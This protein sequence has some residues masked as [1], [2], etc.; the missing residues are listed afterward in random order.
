MSTEQ[1]P[2]LPARPLS[3]AQQRAR[4]AR[5]KAVQIT[6]G[7]TLA[8]VLGWGGWRLYGYGRA[9]LWE[10]RAREATAR[11]DYA[12]AA[13]WASRLTAARPRTDPTGWR[14]LA[15]A[16]DAAAS[17]DALLLRLKVAQLEPG[18]PENLFAWAKTALRLG[19]TDQA[20]DALALV[21]APARD[22][23]PYH[24]L[25]AAVALAAGRP[26]EGEAHFAACT[27][28]EPNNPL[29][30]LNLASLRLQQRGGD[31]DDDEAAATAARTEVGR[32]A[33]AHPD[34]RLP[35]RRALLADAN[36][37]GDRSRALAL[38]RE[39]DAD[40]AADFNDR[41]AALVALQNADDPGYAAALD[42]RQEEALAHPEYVPTLLYWLA[43]H[44][45]TAVGVSWSQAVQARGASALQTV[46]A[47]VAVADLLMGEKDWSGLRDYLTPLDWRRLDFIR[48]AMLA[49]TTRELDPANYPT[50]WAALARAVGNQP[51][52]ALQVARLVRP[53][54]WATE[55]EEMLWRAADRPSLQQ[56]AAL[57]ELFRF[58]RAA[59]NQTS[60][61]LKT[62]RRQW[63][64]DRD[65]PTA[66]NNY[67]YLGLLLG[68]DLPRAHELAAGL[69]KQHPQNPS[70]ASTYAFSALLRGDPA[71]G[72]AALEQI[73]PAARREPGIILVNAL[74]T[75]AA[76]RPEQAR[77]M[78]G[79]TPRASLLPEEQ[80]LLRTIQE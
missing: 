40:P 38:A 17:P 32:I 80:T 15:D 37:R 46:P 39:M 7:L 62:A 24:S 76:G 1:V 45:Q 49:R 56:R 61:L 63:E 50:A 54:G 57:A 16:A 68:E 77:E 59:T 52:L 65:D 9:R 21:P 35:A 20:A 2:R 47:Q 51:E 30:A 18:V 6:L 27:R 31:R 41:L 67:A 74:L 75:A 55:T 79:N 12:S 22:S 58:Y 44:G 70:I 3:L 66:Q 78:V 5:R 13:F 23:I 72:L 28:L 8:L 26:A 14:L 60:R 10:Q 19:R 69:H 48:R 36:R 64:L 11:K 42:A 73:P 53:W 25:A 71:A 43:N 33:A 34:L 29:H 4:R